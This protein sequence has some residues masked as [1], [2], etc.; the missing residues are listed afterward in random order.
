MQ[1]EPIS[2]LFGTVANF[3]VG[4]RGL[5]CWWRTSSACLNPSAFKTLKL[6]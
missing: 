5:Y 1:V 6:L 4:A 3:P 2:H